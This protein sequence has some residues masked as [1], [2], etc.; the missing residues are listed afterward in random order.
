MFDPNIGA[1]TRWQKGQSG[2]PGGRPR[3]RILS[4]A[5]RA[6]LGQLKP[7]DP[8]GR[9]FAE[10]VAANLV[11]I[12]CSSGPGALAAA[13]EITNRL[14]GRAHQ[15]VE[16]SDVTR[17]LRSK[18]DGELQHY[19]QFGCWPEDTQIPSSV[20]PHVGAAEE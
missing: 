4:E 7:D 18:S 13:N 5:L 8:Q 12:A 1:G 9:T 14:E 16:I 11:E 20:G 15:S 10:I 6:Q 17:E 19:L 2:N 3:S